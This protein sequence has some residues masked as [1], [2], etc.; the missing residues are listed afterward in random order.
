MLRALRT[1]AGR[2][3][4][5]RRRRARR[6]PRLTSE[7]RNGKSDRR[8]RSFYE[9][10][11]QGKLSRSEASRRRRRASPLARSLERPCDRN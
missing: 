9:S 1:R 5:A 10:E 6:I 2:R 4:D 8:G 11:N 3:G 7:A